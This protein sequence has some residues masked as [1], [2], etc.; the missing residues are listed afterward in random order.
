MDNE[1]VVIKR[2]IFFAAL[3]PIVFI[4]GLA[5]GYLF[6]G[7]KPWNRVYMETLATADQ[8]AQV[9]QPAT[10]NEVADI[11]RASTEEPESDE[12]S[13]QQQSIRRYDVPVDEDPTLGP[14]DA[15]ITLVEF[16]DY[17]CSFCKKWHDDVFPRIVE[18][19]G[20]QVQIVYR[21]FPIESIHP[22]SVSAAEAA[23]C[24]YEQGY[25]WEYHELLFESQR[26]L[27]QESYRAYAEEIGL[28]L[29]GFD[30]CMEEN[31]FNEEVMDDLEF[32]AR[33]GVRS[34][35]TF[36]LNGIAVV[37]A[38]PFEVFKEVIEKELAGEFE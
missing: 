3:L 37:G 17:Q 16:S 29:D 15:Q 7:I 30:T 8:E 19:Y 28:D 32:A 26:G 27:G 36:F 9:T 33:L 13:G 18:E 31:R 14:D 6:W 5:T 38:Q 23:N 25:F 2:S 24:A 10:A 21:D 11:E 22:E 35:P 20:D 4:L 1:P 34:T 12:T